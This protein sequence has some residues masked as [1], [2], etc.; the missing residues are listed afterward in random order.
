M[1]LKQTPKTLFSFNTLHVKVQATDSADIV[2][3]DS[4]FNTLHVK[5]QEC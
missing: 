5:V 4:S 2:V 1:I 3:R